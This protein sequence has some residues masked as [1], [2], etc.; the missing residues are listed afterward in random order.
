MKDLHK[1]H[2]DI[3][4]MELLKDW[5]SGFPKTSSPYDFELV[6]EAGTPII[7]LFKAYLSSKDIEK[8]P[9]KIIHYVKNP[10]SL[11]VSDMLKTRLHLVILI[12]SPFN[13]AKVCF[14][15]DEQMF[16]DVALCIKAGGDTPNR[17]HNFLFITEMINSENIG[18]QRILVKDETIVGIVNN[19]DLHK[20]VIGN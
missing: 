10:K 14:L 16:G 4:S 18:I 15:R 12:H 1:M 9:K 11:H 7:G 17:H 5:S 6:E 13:T 8:S 3:P 19:L 20:Q 2:F